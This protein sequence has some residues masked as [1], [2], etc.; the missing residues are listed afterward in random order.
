MLHR[1]C[2]AR[3]RPCGIRQRDFAM[4][5]IST[6][7]LRGARAVSVH[8]CLMPQWPGCYPDVVRAVLRHACNGRPVTVALVDLLELY[9]TGSFEPVLAARHVQHAQVWRRRIGEVDGDGA[10]V[11]RGTCHMA[12]P[13]SSCGTRR[14]AGRAASRGCRCQPR[15]TCRSSRRTGTRVLSRGVGDVRKNH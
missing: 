12:C 4:P 2:I 14:T 11:G 9:I 3:R 5:S 6:R 13:D 8:A 10:R 15:R 7:V 1:H